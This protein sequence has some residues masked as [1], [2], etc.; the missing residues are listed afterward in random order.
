MALISTFANGSK[1][2]FCIKDTHLKGI[3]LD[4]VWY[5][6][7]LQAPTTDAPNAT[8]IIELLNDEGALFMQEDEAFES[9]APYE[10]EE[11]GTGEV[12]TGRFNLTHLD[13]DI[14]TLAYNHNL[15]FGDVSLSK[16]ETH[17]GEVSVTLGDMGSM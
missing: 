8:H 13:A 9:G 15:T 3:D 5:V 10:D 14:L 6:R 17:D 7:V 1:P 4:D 2:S 11:Y 16:C 12:L